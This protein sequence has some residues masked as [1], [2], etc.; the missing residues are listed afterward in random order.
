MI[1]LGDNTG[2]YEPFSPERYFMFFTKVREVS[3]PITFPDIGNCWLWTAYI[4][5]SGYG[6]F[7]CPGFPSINGNTRS[8]HILAHRWCVAFW[9]GTEILR[10]LTWDH[11]CLRHACVHPRHGKAITHIE[12]VARGNQTRHETEYDALEF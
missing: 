3:P 8:R 12:N 5:V 7:Y 4:D 11:I 1:R 9:Y 10:G 6:R 2:R